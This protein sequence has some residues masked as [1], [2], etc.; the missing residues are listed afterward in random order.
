MADK[1]SFEQ[2]EGTA[3]LPDQLALKTLS[4]EARAYLWSVVYDS[5][6]PYIRHRNM[7]GPPFLEDPWQGVMRAK[8]LFRDHKMRDEFVNNAGALIEEMKRPFDQGT[9][10]EVLGLVEWLL[11]N[12]PNLHLSAQIDAALRASRCAYRVFDGDTIG[13]AASAEEGEALAKALKDASAGKFDGAR[14]HLKNAAGYASAGKWNDSV[15]ESMH[16]VESVARVLAPG[17]ST[18]DPALKEL[19]KTGKVHEALQ[20]GFG[21][22]YGFTSDEDGI[23]HALLD[24]AKSPVDEADA[25]YMLGACASFVSYLISKTKDKPAS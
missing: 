16:A 15:R 1:L 6:K 23:R 18:L 14:T 3:P 24:D 17:A 13:P 25:L 22:L 7:G 10:A 4:Q 8:H 20:Q 9:Y 19:K 11:R 12:A 2:R 5:M 21:K